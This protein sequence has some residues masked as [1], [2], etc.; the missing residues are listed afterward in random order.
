MP[1]AFVL[2]G[3]ADVMNH[4]L[5]SPKPLCPLQFEFRAVPWQDSDGSS[6]DLPR[7]RVAGFAR[8]FVNFQGVRTCS[9][10]QQARTASSAL[11]WRM[12]VTAGEAR[13][14]STRT[15][16]TFV[17]CTTRAGDLRKQHAPITAVGSRRPRQLHSHPALPSRILC[18]TRVS[19]SRAPAIWKRC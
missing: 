7:D 1:P 17:S 9:E 14:V 6:Q 19:R 15:R 13:S 8:P 16:R 4:L 5:P 18:R 3:V 10:G 11:S 2:R 12:I